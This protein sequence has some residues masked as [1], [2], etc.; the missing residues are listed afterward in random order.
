MQ[1]IKSYSDLEDVLGR[2]S[3]DFFWKPLIEDDGSLSIFNNYIQQIE[4]SQ[5]WG[6]ELNQK[7]GALLEDFSKFLFERFQDTVVKMNVKKTDN[8]SDL[9][10]DLCRKAQ[11]PFIKEYIGPKI[12]CECKNKKTTSVDVGMVTKLAELIPDRGARFGIFISIKGIG[13][14][15]WRYGEGKRKKIFCKT[16]IPIISFTVNELKKLREGQNLYTMIQQKVNALIDEIDDDSPDIPP[17]KHTEYTKRMNEIIAHLKK[18]ELLT[19]EEYQSLSGKVGERY[20]LVEV[21]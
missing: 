5:S 16:D 15:G 7:K 17:D 10:I 19:D 6:R 8:E 18:C 21:G 1:P 2:L 13:G 20:G 11:P 12:I 14:Y 4:E 3:D 9:E